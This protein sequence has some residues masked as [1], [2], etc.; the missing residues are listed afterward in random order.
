MPVRNKPIID[1]N[2]LVWGTMR[3]CCLDFDF[4]IF[5]RYSDNNNFSIV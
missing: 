2:Y 1:I 5:D 4:I 3:I